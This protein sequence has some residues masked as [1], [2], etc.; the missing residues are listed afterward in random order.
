MSHPRSSSFYQS[1]FGK[2]I[3]WHLQYG[4]A[5]FPI[6][7]ITAA[8]NCT[9]HKGE[10]CGHPG[11]HPFSAHGFKDASKDPEVI[12][13]QFD[14]REDLNV[15]IATGRGSG[16]VVIDLD[17]EEGEASWQG[18]TG[19][20]PGSPPPPGMV[21][22]TGK[23]R[24]LLFRHPVTAVKSRQKLAGYEGIDV[25][26]DGGYIVAPPSTHHSGRKYRVD[27]ETYK[28]G[29]PHAPSWLLAMLMA[30]APRKER[31]A[32]YSATSGAVP[33]WEPDEVRAMLDALDPSMGYQEWIEIGMALHSGGFP[34]SMWDGWSSRGRQ[35][36]PGCCVS[37]WRSFKPGG[38]TMGT[39]VERARLRGWKPQAMERAEREPADIACVMPLVEKARARWLAEKAG[40]AGADPETGE[41]PGAEHPGQ[42]GFDPMD[43]PGMI[44]DTVRWIARHAIYELP[45]LAL[46][47][48]LAFAGACM[49][50]R[51]ASPMDTRTNIYL[52]GVDTSGGGKDF[53]RKMI[54]KLAVRS[55]LGTFLGSNDIRSASGLAR[56]LEGRASQLMMLDEFGMM[57]QALNDPK[58]PPYLREVTKLIMICYSAS[59]SGHDHGTYGDAKQK[60]ITLNEPNLCIYGT[61]TLSS[62]VPAL[63][64]S[65]VESGSLNRFIVIPN[66]VEVFVKRN[67]PPVDFPQHLIEAWARLELTAADGLGAGNSCLLTGKQTLVE[68]GVGV[69]EEVYQMQVAQLEKTKRGEPLWGRYVENAIKVAM[70]FAVARDTREPVISMADLDLGKAIV[71]RSVRYMEELTREHMAENEHEANG[72][73]MLRFIKSHGRKGVGRS[74]LL[75]QFRKLKRRD[76]DELLGA[77]LEQGAVE[78]VEPEMKPANRP[79]VLYRAI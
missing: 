50:R 40:E 7:G 72:H 14:C 77:L 79:P 67:V 24:H 43:L 59:N 37:H 17:G 44:G 23:G 3:A 75:R 65:A 54:R 26:A 42:F 47:N 38:I 64:K 9:C 5:V 73:E 68:W 69:E 53:S 25:R 61:T 48:A 56:D 78:I 30:E 4:F 41:L 15:G 51:Y 12:A 57:L 66:T 34:L 76:M 74:V 36:K 27:G 45:E 11:K 63:K 13:R 19:A 2:F 35:Y 6:H 58:S 32:D 60:P 1:S 33:Q 28:L 29:I 22:L 10:A 55:G 39:L 70:I 46:L 62:Y 49:G 20:H 31:E 18:I 8:G 52:V 71:G 16:I 21:F